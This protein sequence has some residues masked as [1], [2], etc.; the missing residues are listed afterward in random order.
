MAKMI[1][2]MAAA[3]QACDGLVGRVD[4]GMG[5]G[6]VVIRS[7]TKPANPGAAPSDG[8]VLSTIALNGPAF[9]GATDQTTFA[10]AL[11]V[12]TPAPEQAGATASG[13]ASWFR[14]FDGNDTAHWDGTCGGSGS[15]EDMILSTA[16]IT[17]GEPVRILS[18][19]VRK[20]T[21]ETA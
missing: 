6:Y 16:T 5:A 21:G 11:A 17:M 20:P 1:I 13:T 8:A 12:V 19:A 15:G 18:W 14:V 10:Q 7:G 3:I 4:G 2:S 9:A